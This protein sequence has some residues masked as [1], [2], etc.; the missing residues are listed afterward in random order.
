MHQRPI[1]WGRKA[2]GFAAGFAC[3]S[4]IGMVGSVLHTRRI[5]PGPQAVQAALFMGTILAVGS[6]IRTN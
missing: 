1:D 3:G 6:A 2:Q 5:P 4:M